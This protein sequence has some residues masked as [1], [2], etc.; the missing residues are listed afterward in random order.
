MG[1]FPAGCW[2]QSALYWSFSTLASCRPDA[3]SRKHIDIYRRQC[4]LQGQF[5]DHDLVATLD[6][7]EGQ[8]FPVEI[9]DGLQTATMT[10]TRLLKEGTGTCKTPINTVTPQIDAGTVYSPDEKYLQSTLREPGSCELRMLKGG[11]LPLSAPEHTS[12]SATPRRFFL[13]GDLRVNEHAVLTSM[14]TLWVRIYCSP[15]QCM[16]SCS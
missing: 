1:A 3:L 9:T 15:M 10:L 13:A 11:F 16:N 14:H 12:S 4:D 5:L 7:H 2:Q 6:N 8:A